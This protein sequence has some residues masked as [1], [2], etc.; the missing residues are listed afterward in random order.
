VVF[1]NSVYQLVEKQGSF[2]LLALSPPPSQPRTSHPSTPASSPSL[3]T[4]ASE[5]AG[6]EGTFE[7][8]ESSGTPASSTSNPSQSLLTV[9]LACRLKPASLAATPT[10]TQAQRVRILGSF[11]ETSSSSFNPLAPASPSPE[12]SVL[13]KNQSNRADATV[14]LDSI[15]HSYSTDY[16]AL[17][18]G[19]NRISV[20]VRTFGKLIHEQSLFFEQLP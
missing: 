1:C 7:A 18:P 19:L 11:C 4:P 17:S 10:P 2:K 12:W 13:I 9:S 16:I 3:R 8:P 15:H 5:G 14:F 20:Q 6:S